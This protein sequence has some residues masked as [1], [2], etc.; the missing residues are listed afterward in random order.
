MRKLE[1][2]AVICI[3]LALLLIAGLGL[4]IGKL[5]IHGDEW[6]SFYGNTHV[7]KD[8]KMAVGSVYDRNGVLLLKN[9]EEGQHYHEDSIVRRATV[10]VVGDKDQNIVTGATYAF[11]SD[12]VG[13]N[14]ITG[15]KGILFGSG[16]SM[17][18]TIDA[19]VSKVAYQALGNRNGLVGVY[20][21]KTGEIICAVSKPG[22]DPEFSTGNA[23]TGTYINKVISSKAI[24]GS[25]F[26]LVTAAAA[27]EKIDDIKTRKFKCTGK[28]KID[29]EYV[30][31]QS[32]HGTMD[33]YGALANSCNCAFAEMTLEM[34]K[35][36]MKSKVKELGLTSAYDINGIKSQKGNFDFDTAKI[37]LGWSGI[38][39][40]NDQVN[41]LSMMVFMG[42]IAGEGTAA[43]PNILMDS[44]VK[45]TT[46]LDG[47]VAKQLKE[48]MRNNVLRT[49]GESNYPGLNLHAKSG[50]AEGA[51]GEATNAWFCGFSGD[52]AFIVCVEKGGYGSQAAGP[53]AN[54]VLQALP[55]ESKD[56]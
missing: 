12:M 13:Y 56:N 6:A 33:F 36:T 23:E 16:R 15:T 45:T 54:K 39:Q 49:Y 34:G 1:G 31:C 50:T 48:M 25:T 24:P 35:G 19:Q 17:A 55:K 26:K 3:M 44:K 29:G 53:V 9:D 10:H 4:F 28:Y 51:K 14:L 47:E 22:L 40:G 11:K 27:I 7:Y 21:W 5:V 46:L 30:T 41:P 42:A 38:G 8:G 37:T 20:N 18:L 52:Y 43:E 2:R 32:V